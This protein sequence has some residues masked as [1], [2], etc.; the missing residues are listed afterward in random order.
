M[1]RLLRKVAGLL[2][3]L[4]PIEP[5]IP[6]YATQLWFAPGDDL[7]VRGEL[8]RADFGGLFAPGAPWQDSLRHVDVMQL[9]VPWFRRM[10]PQAAETVLGFMRAHRIGLAVPF[11]V[12]ASATCGMGVEG[13]A[14]PGGLEANLRQLQQKGAQITDAVL[15]E[16]LFYGA[17][18]NGPASCHMALAEVA[19]QAAA[20]V[21]AI[22][23]Y[24]PAARI[25]LVEPE[26]ALPGGPAELAA[27]LDAFRQQSGAYPDTVRFDIAWHKDWAGAI[28]EFLPLLQQRRIGIGIIF[29][30]TRGGAA[31]DDAAWT[32]SARANT[33]AFMAT[34]RAPLAQAV[35]QSWNARPTRVLP[36]SDPSTMTGFLNWYVRRYGER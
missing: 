11:S 35:I 27:F 26:Q 34:I 18:F 25:H 36:E 19:A 17:D 33:Q 21:R 8:Q 31:Q 1:R 13:I 29:N 28:P 16:P 24:F 23:S 15:D 14:R 22:H 7:D 10:P 6:A 20:G 32:A 5:L 30:A 3:L 2:A 4:A 12:V 9:R